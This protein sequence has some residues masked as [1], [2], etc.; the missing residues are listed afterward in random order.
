[1][2]FLGYLVFVIGVW[3]MVS[4]QAILGLQELKWI[5]NYAFAGEA[6]IGA[7]VCS[8]SLLMIGKS[9]AKQIENH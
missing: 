5:A 9:G 7:L 1:M 3:M 4:P 8:V 6:F 2:K